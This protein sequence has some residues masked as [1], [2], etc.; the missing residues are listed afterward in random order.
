MCYIFTLVRCKHELQLLIM[1]SQIYF[2][3]NPRDYLLFKSHQIWLNPLHSSKEI[4]NPVYSVGYFKSVWKWCMSQPQEYQLFLCTST[5]EIKNY[6]W[7]VNIFYYPWSEG[8]MFPLQYVY[9][10]C[11]IRSDN[12]VNSRNWCAIPKYNTKG[13]GLRHNHVTWTSKKEYG[14]ADDTT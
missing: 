5:L 9:K 14:H 8:F 10:W 11:K 4:W 1:N 3:I 12:V 6:N 2:A 13:S 7:Y